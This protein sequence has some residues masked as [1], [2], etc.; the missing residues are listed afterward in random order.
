MKFS[1][2]RCAGWFVFSAIWGLAVSPLVAGDGVVTLAGI[3][4]R[5]WFGDGGRAVDAGV[6]EPYGLEIGPDGGLYVCETVGHVVRRIDLETG[7][8]ST[9]VGTGEPG[10]D[11][12]GGPATSARVEQPYEVRFDADGNM[13]FV[14]MT[15][16]VVRRVDAGTRI[17]STVAGCGELGFS[18]DGGPATAAKLNRPH[19]ICL[20]GRGNLYIC[21]IGNHRIRVV[22][23][24]TGLIAT[25]GGTGE[26]AETPDG[27]P[28][29]GTPLN[30]PRALAFDGERSLYLVLREGNMVY[31]IDLDAR[32]LHHVGGTG[33][34]GYS[35]DGGDARLATFRGPKGIAMGPGGNVYVADTQNHAIR[36]IDR[37]SGVVETLIGDGTEGDGPDGDPRHCRLD[38]PHG[39]FVGADGTVFVG[40]SEN[41][42]VRALAPQ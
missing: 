39:V 35:G 3:G 17:I 11:G 36:V 8:I 5:R 1:V 22:D 24:E 7:E 32:T 29:A 2:C 33:E 27:A 13:Y 34:K 31:R 10:N 9:V 23:L 28:L 40:D 20:D 19:S 21:D 12:D 42:R 41:H 37:D 6:A 16:Y 26:R 38:D 25:F 18:G 4:E 14:D 15:R 30:G